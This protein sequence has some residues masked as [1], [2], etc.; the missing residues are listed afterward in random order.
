MAK[1]EV[2]TLASELGL[3]TA[4]KKDSVGI[5]FVGEVSISDFLRSRIPQEP[6]DIVRVSDGAVV[7]RHDGAAPFT[8]GQR[9]GLGVGGGDPL[10]VVTKDMAKN[11]VYVAQGEDPKELYASSLIATDVHWIAGAAPSF[12]LTCKVRIRYRQ[13]LQDAVIHAPAADGSFRIDFASPQRA[14][15]PGQFAVVY[16]GDTCLGGG[17]IDRAG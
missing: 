14:V 1:P 6:G 13:P 17:V 15:S 5:C 12:P 2:R 10:F 3:A 16:L 9:H 11:I 4:N 8:I 7:G